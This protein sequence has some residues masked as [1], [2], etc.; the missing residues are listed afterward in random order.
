MLIFLI[1]IVCIASCH[2]MNNLGYFICFFPFFIYTLSFFLQSVSKIHYLYFKSCSSYAQKGLLGVCPNYAQTYLH[3]FSNTIMNIACDQPRPST[4]FGFN[5]S[6]S[7]CSPKKLCFPAV[8]MTKSNVS[9]AFFFS[10][11]SK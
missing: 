1:K 10:P 5:V 4:Q 6:L 3:N 11:V 9:F 7:I 2:T 8:F